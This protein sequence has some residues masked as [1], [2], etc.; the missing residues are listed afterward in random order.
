MLL[1]RNADGDSNFPFSAPLRQHIGGRRSKNTSGRAF[2]SISIHVGQ[3]VGNS[4]NEGEAEMETQTS[5]T[6]AGSNSVDGDEN[7]ANRAEEFVIH[8]ATNA[9]LDEGRKTPKA[10]K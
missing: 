7:N 3:Q 10:K 8:S 6:E 9:E 4:D 5:R 1:S 2:G